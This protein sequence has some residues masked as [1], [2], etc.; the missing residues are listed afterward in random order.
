MAD[1]TPRGLD[2]PTYSDLIKS[3]SSSSALADDFAGL[4]LSADAAITQGVQEAK[5]DATAKYGGLPG[6]VSVLEA[7]MW[8]RTELATNGS[9]DTLFTPGLHFTRT[10][11]VAQSITG[12]P[13][14]STFNNPFKVLVEPISTTNGVYKQTIEA[15]ITGSTKTVT[16]Y[17]TSLSNAYINPWEVVGGD[18]AWDRG[19]M[20]TGDNTNSFTSSGTRYADTAAISGS[21]ISKPSWFDSNPFEVQTRTLSTSS[22]ILLQEA[23]Q[24][25]SGASTIRRAYRVSLS[26]TFLEWIDPD[27]GLPKLRNT[28]MITILGDS[29]SERSSTSWD[30][31]AATALTDTTFV[32]HARSGD[33]SNTVLIREG[34][35]RPVFR[36]TGEVIPA[37]GTVTLTT[38]QPLQVR[39]NRSIIGGTLNGVGGS[40]TFVSGRTWQFTRSTAGDEVPSPGW[41]EFTSSYGPGG[42]A[43]TNAH[44]LIAWFGGNDFAYN[45]SGQERDIADH[46]IGNYRRFIE[47]CNEHGYHPIIAGVTN[48]LAAG[49]ATLGFAMIQRINAELRRMFPDIFLDVQAYYVE[50]AIYDAGL[51]PT[52]ADLDAMSR[53]EI[54]PQLFLADGV[55]LLPAAHAAI[56]QYWIAPWLAEKGYGRTT[57]VQPALPTLNPSDSRPQFSIDTAAGRT[58]SVWDPA[59]GK[60]QLVSGDTGWR[61]M[62]ASFPSLG[63]DPKLSALTIKV[64]R[65]GE[66][67]YLEAVVMSTDNNFPPTTT[68]M[69]NN[70]N[71]FRS[72]G[73]YDWPA[74]YYGSTAIVVGTLSTNASI[75]AQLVPNV[76]LP[77]GLRFRT[78][79]T[80]SDPWPTTLPG[81]PV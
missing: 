26:G 20:A 38:D 45:M 52:Q 67:V 57:T 81:T 17:R 63:N 7:N 59:Q 12:K 46:I 64:R 75:R 74:G 4:A 50:R 72:A 40:L 21:I 37:S 51:T 42:N 30:Q 71:G 55:H 35:I 53:G 62:A 15:K 76:A 2:Y 6:R 56:G 32:N 28:G 77:A 49:F 66:S 47:Y 14:D 16:M 60:Y 80:T 41:H 25:V 68:V 73:N 79:W 54:P 18:L 13:G 39:E 36:V 70:V 78:Q 24:K 29:Q 23:T 69:S 31:A 43:Q 3:G 65:V 27:A 5:D 11:Q 8:A 10:A 48:R 9:L 34:I 22:G 44:A 33:E 58:V 19:R 1:S 61:E